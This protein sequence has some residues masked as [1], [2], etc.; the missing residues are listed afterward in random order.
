MIWSLLYT[1]IITLS[2]I[3]AMPFMMNYTLSRPRKERQ[4]QYSALYSIA[5]G[6]ANIA[7]PAL[8]LGIAAKY[9]FNSMFNFL[10]VLSLILAAAFAMLNNNTK[11]MVR[12]QTIS[13]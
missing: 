8:G 1:I 11:R 3:F 5:Y 4:G 6:I 7:A 13:A 12:A 9:G 2:E 10:I